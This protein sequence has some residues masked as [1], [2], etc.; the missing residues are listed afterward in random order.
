M[1]RQKAVQAGV[2]TI[3]IP[4]F[5]EQERNINNSLSKGVSVM[6]KYESITKESVS[7]LL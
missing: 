5:L 3:G 2:P 4:F 6:L 7:H 1:G